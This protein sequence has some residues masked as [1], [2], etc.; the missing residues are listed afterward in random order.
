VQLLVAVNETLLP[1]PDAPQPDQEATWHFG[2]T[3][4]AWAAIAVPG[5]YWPVPQLGTVSIIA[6][7]VV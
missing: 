3:A 7:P 6:E 1:L 5:V 2:S 4:T